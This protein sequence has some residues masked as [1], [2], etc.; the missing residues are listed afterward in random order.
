MN[1]TTTSTITEPTVLKCPECGE[2]FTTPFGLR[3]HKARKHG[4]PAK[5]AQWSKNIA[6][7]QAPT[8]MAKAATK[9]VTTQSPQQI[10]EERRQAQLAYQKAYRMKAKKQKAR[11]AAPAPVLSAK[12]IQRAKVQAKPTQACPN[13]CPNCGFSM[14]AVSVAMTIN[15]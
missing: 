11:E 15:R 3:V 6:R 4:D 1:E 14:Q 13:F 7:A 8:R 10:Q 2:E 12:E 5:M 9:R